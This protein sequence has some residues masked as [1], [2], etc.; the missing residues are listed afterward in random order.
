MVPGTRTAL[1]RLESFSTGSADEVVAALKEIKTAGADRLVLDLRGNPGGYVNEAVG[2][3]SQFLSKG[4]VYV[5]RDADGNETRHSGHPERRRLRPAARRARR[6][7]HGQ[8]GGDPL[9]R[10]PGRGRATVVGVQTF[11]TGTVLGEFPLSDGSALRIGTVEWLTPDGRRIWHE[12]MT[13]IVTVE[14]AG[15]RRTARRRTRSRA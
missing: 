8:L 5:E 11:G 15:R 7:R 10:A 13:P 12:G 2:I 1:L 14:R 4:D 9:R 6:R 3:A